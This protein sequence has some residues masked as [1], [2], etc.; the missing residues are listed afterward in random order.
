MVVGLNRCSIITTSSLVQILS[1]I[2]TERMKLITK[3]EYISIF[4]II[5]KS[6]IF[7]ISK[8]NSPYSLN[9]ERE[10]GIVSKEDYPSIK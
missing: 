4:G 2:M 1:K 3:R 10:F 8:I 9:K 5:H 7:T 6:L